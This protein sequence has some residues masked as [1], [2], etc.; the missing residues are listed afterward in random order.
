MVGG[1]QAKRAGQ[2]PL[3]GMI[4]GGLGA[5]G[6]AGLASG[7]NAAGAAAAPSANFGANANAV[8][9]SGTAALAKPQSLSAPFNLCHRVWLLDSS[10]FAAGGE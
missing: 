8:V 4:T 6:G 5:Y 9:D 3:T 2:D 10:R 1:Y 7:L